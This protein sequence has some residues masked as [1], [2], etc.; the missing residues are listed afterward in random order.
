VDHAGARRKGRRRE[1]LRPAAGL[2]LRGLGA[3]VDVP[4]ILG[5]RAA[6]MVKFVGASFSDSG[7][8]SSK[9]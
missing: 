4:A 8:E 9:I 7:T 3:E 5:R 6:R 1:R 2:K